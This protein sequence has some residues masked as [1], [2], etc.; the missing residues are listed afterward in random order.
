MFVFAKGAYAPRGQIGFPNENMSI[1]MVGNHI[2]VGEPYI[3]RER[4]TLYLKFVRSLI[5]S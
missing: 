4:K 3:K 1:I 5:M 2:H